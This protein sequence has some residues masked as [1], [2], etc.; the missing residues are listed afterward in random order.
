MVLGHHVEGG[1]TGTSTQPKEDSHYW[2]VEKWARE[3]LG[4]IACRH[5]EAGNTTV[6]M[7]GRKLTEEERDELIRSGV[8]VETTR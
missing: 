7:T 5:A 2:R 8:R 1:V 4:T 6:L 3:M